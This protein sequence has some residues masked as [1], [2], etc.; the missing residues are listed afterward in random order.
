MSVPVATVVVDTLSVSAAAVDA[1]PVVVRV[2]LLLSRLLLLLRSYGHW[3]LSRDV[4]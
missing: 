2:S 1:G 3:D 4:I